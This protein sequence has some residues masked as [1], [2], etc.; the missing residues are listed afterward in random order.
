MDGVQ[1]AILNRR[2]N[3]VARKMANTLLR[4]GRSGILAIARDFSCCILTAEDQLI[5]FAESLPVHI[6]SG[7]DV[8][9]RTISVSLASVPSPATKDWSIFTVVTGKR[10]R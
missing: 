9:A 1:L 5:A 6:L 4:T 8:M 3:G 2:L 7:P 10:F